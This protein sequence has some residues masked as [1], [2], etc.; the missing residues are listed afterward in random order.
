MLTVIK[1]CLFIMDEI[2][3][4]NSFDFA[5]HE[6]RVRFGEFLSKL[7]D[8]AQALEDLVREQRAKILESMESKEGREGLKWTL[9]AQLED[10]EEQLKD[11][12]I[13]T[14]STDAPEIHADEES[15]E[16]YSEEEFSEEAHYIDD[17]SSDEDME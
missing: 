6:D 1:Q 5:K 4:K 7:R 17:R 9:R 8:H 3:D 12:G 14:E 10:V 15:E 2:T 16:E 11:A 13:S